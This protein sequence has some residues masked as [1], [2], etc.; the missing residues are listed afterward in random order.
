MASDKK[1]IIKID[2]IT[3]VFDNLK[4]YT[5]TMRQHEDTDDIPDFLEKYVIDYFEKTDHDKSTLKQLSVFFVDRFYRA[6]GN[7]LDVFD[8]YVKLYVFKV[9]SNVW[10][11]LHEKDIQIFYLVDN[12]FDVP[13][14][15]LRLRSILELF[16]ASGFAV[17]TPYDDND[18]IVTLDNMQEAINQSFSSSPFILY[19]EKDSREAYMDDV[20]KVARSTGYLSIGR[21]K[22]PDIS[23][24]VVLGGA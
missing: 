9:V 11:A 12:N 20:A 21:S 1:H 14:G 15:D 17:I 18:N 10:A 23:E 5:D 4:L 7:D 8:D 19:I 13:N 2:E 16:E 3:D 24:V 6:L 22:S